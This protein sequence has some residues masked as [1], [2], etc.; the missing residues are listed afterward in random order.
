MKKRKIYQIILAAV[1][2]L[3]AALLCASA[4]SVYLEGSARRAKNPLENIY[5]P[6]IAAEKLTRIAPLFL[7]FIILLFAGLLP[8]LRKEK[9][10]RKAGSAGTGSEPPAVRNGNGKKNGALQTVVVV[11]AVILIIAGI[12][13]GSAYDVLIKAITICTECIGLG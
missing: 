3:L 2:I 8:G 1:S 11:T 5:T 6:G 12:L 4:V 7:L 13:N 9:K 10:E